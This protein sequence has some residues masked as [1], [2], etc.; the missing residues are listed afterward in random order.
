MATLRPLRLL[1]LV[2]P[3]LL[4]TSFASADEGVTPNESEV[5]AAVSGTSAEEVAPSPALNAQS[6]MVCQSLNLA[7]ASAPSA[8]VVECDPV[9]G[10]SCCGPEGYC[11]ES[12]WRSCDVFP[13][14]PE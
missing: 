11:C 12:G 14:E 8:C 6:S 9:F 1:V 7:F 5:V 3:F 10:G 2:I 4:I 13:C